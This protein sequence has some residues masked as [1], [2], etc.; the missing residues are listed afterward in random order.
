[1][2]LGS[3]WLFKEEPSHY[4][5][6][7]LVTD[8][9]TEWNGVRNNLALKHLS[10]IKSGDHIFFYHTGNEKC[11]VGI[12]VAVGDAA[13]VE[14]NDGEA[15]LAVKVRPVRKLPKAVSLAQ[16]KADKRFSAFELVRIPRLSVM[17]VRKELWDAIL[18]LAGMESKY[19]F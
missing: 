3:Y 19:N 6:D 16:I 12:M 15:G 13:G 5:W 1:L 9:E 11:V 17:P 14:A 10:H 8:G 2:E 18:D 4:S 7:D